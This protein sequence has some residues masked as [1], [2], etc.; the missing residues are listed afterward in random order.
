MDIGADESD[1]TVWPSGSSLIIRVSTSGNDGNDGSSWELAKRTVQAGINA[2]V[3]SAGQVWV[4]GGTYVE[5]IVLPLGVAVFGG[6]GGNETSLSQRNWIA[7][8]TVLDGNRSG[9]VVTPITG[10]TGSTRIDGFILRNGNGTLSGTNRFGGG[11]YCSGASPTVANCTIA[12]NTVT[13]SGGGIYCSGS[14]P[15]VLSTI[16]VGNTA[17]GSGGGLFCDN[18]YPTVLHCTI[19]ANT[20]GGGGGAVYSYAFGSLSPTIANTILAFNSSGI[21]KSGGLLTLRYSCVF[22][23]TAYNYSGWTDQ[24]GTSGNRSA[25]PKFVRQASAGADGKWGTADD[26]CGDLRLLPGSPCIDAGSNADV[27]ADT[28]DLNGNG[29]ITEPLPF[30]L[31]GA[32]RF[33]DDSYAPDTGL[34]TAPIVDIGAYEYHCGD[35]SGDGQVDVVDLLDLADAWGSLA[36]DADYN[37]ASDFNHDGSV[38]VIDL[39]MLARNWGT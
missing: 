17:S 25:D 18:S 34:G 29:N 22:G 28:V 1:G 36:G 4:G 7:H 8:G 12:G 31:A 5:R 19:T 16:L 11:I 24:T 37:A 2:A 33:A 20:V 21:Q 35:N 13:G 15:T 26:N 38:D 10:V 23:N 27:P 9:S 39:L 32:S 30:D 3:P 6:F 14:S